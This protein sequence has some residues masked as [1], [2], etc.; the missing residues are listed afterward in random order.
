MEERPF[1]KDPWYCVALI[2][3]GVLGLTA[4]CVWLAFRFNT[5][6][7]AGVPFLVVCG[8]MVCRFRR[9]PVCDQK[10]SP[11]RQFLGDPWDTRF[12]IVLDCER[13]Q[14]AW[15][16]EVVGDSKFDEMSAGD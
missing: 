1:P 12:R 10:L 13:C 8:I 6:W 11:R 9:C 7:L 15:K 16:T 2:V 5:V 4:A 14:I 3:L